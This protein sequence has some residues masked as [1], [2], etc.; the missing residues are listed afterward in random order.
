MIQKE[1]GFIVGPI[2]NLL[3]YIL[4]FIFEFAYLIT[5][6]NSLGL[7]IILFTIFTRAIMLPLAFKQQKSMIATQK[8]A[9]EVE[10]IKKKYGKDA[11][12]QQKMNI[13]IQAL[14]TKH[15]ISPLTGC[16]P[17]FIQFPIF[18]AL[19]YMMQQSYLFINKIGE[20][21][22]QIAQ[23]LLNIPNYNT[24]AHNV[25]R[26]LAFSKVP[27]N[28]IIDMANIGDL[29]K[30]LNR[31][32]VSD[33]NTLK[34]SVP[35]ELLNGMESVLNQKV[36]IEYFFGLNLTEKSGYGFP[37]VII[38][39]LACLTTFLSS[40]LIMKQTP[41]QTQDKNIE[42]QQ[43]VMLYAM[44]ILMGFMTVGFPSGVGLYWIT[45]SVFQVGQQFFINKYYLKKEPNKE[46]NE[47]SQ[48][49]STEKKG[50]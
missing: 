26:P 12:Q 43:K 4:N 23:A 5:P 8:L 24:F 6:A 22:N 16:L 14:Y 33:W 44:P 7:S 11:E 19:S 17:M 32:T 50:V 38:P 2:T 13:E 49:K 40:Y 36:S 42:V 41:K 3:G 10:K 9:P 47:Q 31:L 30:I 1:P 37:G 27:K 29:Q 39:I 21:Y 18:I 15:N 35:S 48:R 34:N 20:I 28:M 46:N 45:S 25:L